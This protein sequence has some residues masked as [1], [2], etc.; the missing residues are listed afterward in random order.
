MALVIDAGRVFHSEDVLGMK[1]I[2]M[3]WSDK[4][5]C[6]LHQNGQCEMKHVKGGL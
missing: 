5:E 1:D 2:N 4:M 6:Q 3:R